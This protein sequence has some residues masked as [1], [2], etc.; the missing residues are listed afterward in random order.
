MKEKFCGRTLEKR[1]H[2]GTFGVT[3]RKVLDAFRKGVSILDV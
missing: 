3:K 2:F 1:E